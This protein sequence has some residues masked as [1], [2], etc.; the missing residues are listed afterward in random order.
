MRAQAGRAPAAEGFLRY[1]NGRRQ[2]GAPAGFGAVVSHGAAEFGAAAGAGTH[3][4]LSVGKVDMG[5]TVGIKAIKYNKRPY[6]Q[7]KHYPVALKSCDI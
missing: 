6:N 1:G 2:R 4:V 3:G 5:L 7:H